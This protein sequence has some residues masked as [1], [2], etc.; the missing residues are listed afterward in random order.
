[1]LTVLEVGQLDIKMSV[2][3]VPGE[4]PLLGQQHHR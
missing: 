3:S 2:D 4:D 1:M